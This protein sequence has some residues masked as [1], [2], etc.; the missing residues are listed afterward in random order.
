MS[1]ERK[2]T[3]FSALGIWIGFVG[4]K[5]S[6]LPGE[7]FLLVFVLIALA[8]LARQAIEWNRERR[9]LSRRWWQRLYDTWEIL[10]MIG[11]ASAALAI[12]ASY[13][14]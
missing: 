5:T 10:F 7:V 14:F 2:L 1:W 12:V 8:L 3:I 4:V 6:W 13:F 11:W 9:D